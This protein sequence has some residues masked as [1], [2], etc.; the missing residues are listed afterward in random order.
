VVHGRA[1]AKVSARAA[2]T[3]RRLAYGALALATLA[4]VA[5]AQPVAE[6]ALSE[7]QARAFQQRVEAYRALRARAE[8]REP[9]PEE[10]SEPAEIA[11]RE[12]RLRQ[13]IR[14]ARPSPRAGE[15]FGD[16][17]AAFRA[18]GRRNFAART[19]AE[20]TEWEKQLPR[21]APPQPNGD[22]PATLPLATFPPTLLASLPPL[23]E[24]VEYR[25]VGRALL[26][27]DVTANLV[28]DVLPDALPAPTPAAAA[29]P[30]P[31]EQRS[32]AAP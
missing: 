16:A 20:R 4:G 32:E 1:R 29:R 25:L 9:A 17:A 2:A 30:D 7:A 3:A 18:A 24:D 31:E 27:R 23:P 26:L 21:R 14:A 28:I 11:G 12:A 13:A 10:T 5:L 6:P 22:Y 19:P 15:V 8:R